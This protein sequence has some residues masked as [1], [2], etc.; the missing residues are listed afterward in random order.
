[1]KIIDLT[2]ELRTGTPVYPSYPIPIV[3]RWTSIREHG[4][5]S[6]I[7]VIVEHTGTHVDAPAHFIEGGTTIDKLPLER[8]IGKAFVVDVSDLPPRSEIPAERV[9]ETAEKLGVKLDTETIV[10]FHT[11]YDRKAGTQE[12]FNHPGLGEE[13]AKLLADRSVK[14]VGIDAPSIDHEPYPAHRI[15]LSKQIPIYENLTNLDKLVGKVFRFIA[16]PLKIVQGSASPVRAV[17]I[18]EE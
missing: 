14:A 5:Y 6:N 4:F 7:L 18:V 11:G 8:F 3:H 17:A 2:M 1:M 12:W 9:A 16:I 13:A 10:L 15:L